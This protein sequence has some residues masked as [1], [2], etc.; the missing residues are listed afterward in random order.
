MKVN[1]IVRL[2]RR[3]TFEDKEL[4]GIILSIS[5]PQHMQKPFVVVMTSAGKKRWLYDDCVVISESR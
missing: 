3:Y 5:I 2:C 1:D 4:I